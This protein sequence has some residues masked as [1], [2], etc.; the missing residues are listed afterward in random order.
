MNKPTLTREQESALEYALRA[1][2]GDK[3][4]VLRLSFGPDKVKDSRF[5]ESEFMLIAA[6]LINGYEVEKTP[7]ER[8][9]E[10]YVDYMTSQEYSIYR[11]KAYAIEEALNILGIKI[12][13]VNV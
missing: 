12:E 6:A 13:G 7:E 3:E 10:R 9:K 1:C 4:Q 8:L 11:A 2:L 5:K